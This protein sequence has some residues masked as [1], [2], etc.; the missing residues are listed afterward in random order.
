MSVRKTTSRAGVFDRLR[1]LARASASS[2][3]KEKSPAITGFVNDVIAQTSK[4]LNS[5]LAC[6]DCAGSS[7]FEMGEIVWPKLR[8]YNPDRYYLADPV[9]IEYEEPRPPTDLEKRIRRSIAYLKQKKG[10]RYCR[11][12]GW[13]NIG[14]NERSAFLVYDLNS[15]KEIVAINADKP[16]QA[17]SMMKPFVALA[18]YHAFEHN[19]LEMKDEEVHDALMELSMRYSDNVATTLLMRLVAEKGQWAKLIKKRDFIIRV[20]R[21]NRRN[22]SHL[23]K[24]P[25]KM[26]G[27]LKKESPQRISDILSRYPIFHDT[28]IV[29]E[30][31]YAGKTYKNKISARDYSRFLRALWKRKLPGS[32]AILHFMGMKNYTRLTDTSSLWKGVRIYDKTGTTGRLNGNMGIL[33]ESKSSWIFVGIIENPEPNMKWPS[34]EAVRRRAH[35]IRH[36]SRWT[37]QWLKTLTR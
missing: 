35:A 19:E 14:Q 23:Y 9:V 8:A 5:L 12:H 11:M 13:E 32:E 6:K 34:W 22:G 3:G 21:L 1:E 26:I 7:D 24:L 30:I 29:E 27:E 16:M 15:K 2:A 25:A 33:V 28:S 17:A 10:G 4:A 18:N 31:N 36:Y 20:L 37:Y